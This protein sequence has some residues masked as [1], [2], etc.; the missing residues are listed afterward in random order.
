M[1]FSFVP[2]VDWAAHL[3]GLL[4]G[5]CTGMI[6]F[7]SWIKT[8]R[9]I[10]LWFIVGS[11]LT[12]VAYYMALQYMYSEVEPMEELKDVCGYYKQYF[13]DY[14]CNCQLQNGSGD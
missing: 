7:S 14:E 1:L 6:C 2:Y 10:V 5:F 12:I 4:A 8:L 13:E 9:Y 11:G 3:G